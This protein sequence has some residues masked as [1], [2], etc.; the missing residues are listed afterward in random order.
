[1]DIYQ[2]H[3]H[4]RISLKKSRLM[5][6]DGVLKV[7]DDKTEKYWR[8]VI[9]DIKKG[10]MSARSIALAY[11]YPG[12]LNRIAKLTLRDR[13]VISSH[14]VS[15]EFPAEDI[16]LDMMFAA[17]IGAIEKEQHSMTQLIGAIKKVIPDHDV[18][19][20]YVAVRILLFA[21]Q[22]DFQINL[23]AEDL[24]RSF[25]SVRDEDSM[26]GWWHTVPGRYDQEATIYHR[27]KDY[28]L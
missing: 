20:Y 24:A 10:K 21:C 7:E 28:D 1:M 2:F 3:E 9:A 4:Y 14:F 17:T 19:Y 22:T 26:R 16:E 25:A 13:R 18:S 12:K 5:Q 11:R 15:V 6:R 23:M 8:Q 27:P